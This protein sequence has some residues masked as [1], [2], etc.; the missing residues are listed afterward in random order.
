M[1]NANESE[2]ET[3]AAKKLTV[4]DLKRIIGGTPHSVDPAED[5]SKRVKLVI[6]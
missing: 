6:E 3:S 1:K 4:E 2:T 5:S